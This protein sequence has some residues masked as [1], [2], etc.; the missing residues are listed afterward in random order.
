M[1]SFR[2]F[3][4]FSQFM[5]KEG[6]RQ[7]DVKFCDLLGGWRHITLMREVLDQHL[8]E[9]GVGFDSSSVPRFNDVRRSDMAARPDLS[10][11][12]VDPVWKSPTLSAIADIVEAG[13]GSEVSLDPRTVLKRAVSHMKNSGV[14]DS[15]MCAPE[16]EFYIFSNVRFVN[17]RFQAGFS[18]SVPGMSDT[19]D[20]GF[21][22]T[23]DPAGGSSA[24]LVAGTR[25]SWHNV[26]QEMALTMAAAGLPVRYHH[27]EAGD[28]GQ[29]EIELYFTPALQA[30]D[31]ILLGKYL[32]RAVAESHKVKAC[33]LPK[34][35]AEAAG[36]GM[37]I[38]FRLLK[39]GQNLFSG[40]GYGG[41]SELGSHFV[42]GILAHGRA[43]LALMCPTTNSYRRLRPGYE[44]P[45]RFFYSAANR[46]AA[47]RIPKYSK[48]VNTRLEFR[49]GD[50][51]MNPYLGIAAMLMAGLDGIE[52][53]LNPS[54]RQLGP[55]DGQPP[56]VDPKQYPECFLPKTLEES[57]DSLERD[58]D[59]LLAGDVFPEALLG[60]F[61]S[62]KR[63][64]ELHLISGAPHPLEY[65]MYWGL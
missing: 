25:D 44:T 60:N 61:L 32:V 38:H 28:A 18:L 5:E 9:K 55:F 40:D 37:H 45:T 46:E 22:P 48:G 50:A 15:F 65:E 21:G 36:S 17:S 64:E 10:A 31:G 7:F 58:H 6:I 20:C 27:V 63:N 41:L 2:T 4:E 26:R 39:D 56:E 33:F 42:G 35:I 53:K 3:D 12:F 54:P 23:C 8:L 1:L 52:R 13:T 43:L 14:A 47:I 59:F 51:L 24:Y 19:F 30:A 34:P 57:L 16:L 49:P 11:C 29:Q 62:Y